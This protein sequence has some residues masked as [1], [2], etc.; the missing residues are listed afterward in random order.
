MVSIDRQGP[1]SRRSHHAFA[2]AVVLAFVAGC[3]GGGSSVTPES[4]T[5]SGTSVASSTTSSAKAEATP[6]VLEETANARIRRQLREQGS[7]VDLARQ[8]FAIEM[9]PLPGVG[10]P[11]GRVASGESGTFATL[12][13]LSVWD[14]LTEPQRAAAAPLVGMAPG[15]DL[16]T[17]RSLG[18]PPTSFPPLPVRSPIKTIGTEGV[19]WVDRPAV[20]SPPTG[21]R[22]LALDSTALDAYFRP[23]VGWANRAIAALTG[24][25]ALADTFDLAF[26]DDPND[27]WAA[28]THF[29][30]VKV[31]G[32]SYEYGRR[33]DCHITVNLAKF[34]G[35]PFDV[36][37]SVLTHETFHCFQQE[38]MSSLTDLNSVGDWLSEGEAT[39]VQNAIVTTAEFDRMREHWN[40]YLNGPKVHLFVR[41]YDAVGW[42]GHLSDVGGISL[43]AQNL[44]PAFAVGVGHA[45]ED[46]FKKLVGELEDK[47]FDSWAASYFQAHHQKKL[48]DMRGPG[49]TAN[50][51]GTGPA[52]ETVSVN[53]GFSATFPKAAPWEL[54]LARLES[55]ADMIEITVDRGHVA[56]IDQSEK[57]NV[58]IMGGEP[59]R[60]C[61]RDACK[62]PPGS[63]GEVPASEPAKAPFDVGLTGGRQG[64]AAHVQGFSIDQY[65]TKSPKPPGPVGGGGTPPDGS[66]GT[67]PLRDGSEP[68][69]GKASSDPHIS[70]FDGR[71]YDLHAQGE[72][73]LSR[74]TIDDFAVQVRFATKGGNRTFT[75][76]SA[77]ATKVGPDR[78]TVSMLLESAEPTP[79]LRINGTLIESD[80][81]V[82]DGAVVRAVRTTFGP[83]YVITFRDGTRV[84]ANSTAREGLSVWVD[85]APERRG[86]LTGLLGDADGDKTNDP[87]TRGGNV[88]AAQPGYDE[89]YS[90]FA[91]S[92][93]ITQAD[94][95]LDYATGETTV[96]FTD[97]S[98]PDR[99]RPAATPDA[100][101]A[102]TVSCT[103]AGVADVDLVRNCAFDL[104]VTRNSDF[105]D[106]YRSQQQRVDYVRT[107][108]GDGSVTPGPQASNTTKPV[109]VEGTIAAATDQPTPT[110]PGGKGDILYVDP[111]NC[112]V[113]RF[114]SILDPAGKELGSVLTCG[115]RYVLPANGQY[116]IRLNPYKDQTGPYR[117]PLRPVRADLVRPITVGEIMT[118]TIAYRAEHD[119]FTLAITSPQTITI[120]G[121]G[122]VGPGLGL[123]IFFGDTLV[124]AGDECRFGSVELP[125]AGT[126][127]LEFNTFNAATGNF[128]VAVAKG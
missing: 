88:L 89:L 18:P 97:V 8:L 50:I 82:L 64:A 102:A 39:W 93:R 120:G 36:Q 41:S 107:F 68:P 101:A 96:T 121:T 112:I 15:P 83:G 37:L 65:C 19:G 100:L 118:G 71:W 124:T 40:E 59:I 123:S 28:T 34:S 6:A 128:R 63:E 35:Q 13:L 51:P 21:G 110:F 69:T 85:P 70:T 105:T 57:F 113:P 16:T 38:P 24:A 48:W 4:S 60:L 72:F 127:R 52:P 99:D 104:A 12:Q 87:I 3:S 75:T 29:Y 62:C 7:N 116:T 1:L 14:Q 44:L 126:Y 114:S 10:A 90:T 86:K 22:V 109:V 32:T 80:S 30:A 31:A 66:S 5:P 125:K 81:V 9:A 77:M 111:A 33:A 25:P 73:V 115:D 45:D 61:L 94:S 95:M 91:A 55:G 58:A 108:R 56:M 106:T 76:A 42:Y 122:C 20:A 92:W 53:A 117:I 23:M 47:A 26:I 98:M 11:T 54:T 27:A 46:A 79:V 74:S 103:A 67:D 119:V 84:G 2:I 49:N 78:V 43:V 17:V